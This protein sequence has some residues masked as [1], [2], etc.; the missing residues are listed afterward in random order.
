MPAADVF[1]RNA[2]IHVKER[3]FFDALLIRITVGAKLGKTVC[4][5][6]FG[7]LIGEILLCHFKGFFGIAVRHVFPFVRYPA[8]HKLDTFNVE[9]L[10]FIGK[11]AVELEP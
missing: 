4:H 2:L 7:Y 3:T 6:S 9:I 11:T 10:C 5:A 1:V 8:E